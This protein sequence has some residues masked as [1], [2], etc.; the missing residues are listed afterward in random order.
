MIITMKAEATQEEIQAVIKKVEE[1]GL[2]I[3]LNEG[4]EKLVISVIG[5]TM[6]DQEALFGNCEGVENAEK[7]SSTYKLTSREFTESTVIDVD[8]IK[9]GDGHFVDKWQAL[10]R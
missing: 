10:V 2:A 9:I 4:L 8:G 5:E 6:K 3:Q 1:A 7:M